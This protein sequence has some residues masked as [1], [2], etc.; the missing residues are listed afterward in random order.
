MAY[1]P[2]IPHFVISDRPEEGESFRS[3]HDI[4][5]DRLAA[6]D[7]PAVRA[8]LIAAHMVRQVFGHDAAQHY[9][10][11]FTQRQLAA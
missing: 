8:A 6:E 1:T 7:A 9:L 2:E 4:A 10:E 5:W 3:A 11:D